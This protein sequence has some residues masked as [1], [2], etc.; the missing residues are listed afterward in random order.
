MTTQQPEALRLADM[1]KMGHSYDVDLFACS[2]E[3]RRQHARIA[4]LEAQL[5]APQSPEAA[6]VQLPE[7]AAWMDNGEIRSGSTATAHRVVTSDTKNSMPNASKVSFVNPLY[8]EQQVRQ[9]L[10]AHGIN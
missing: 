9:L 5:A 4:E 1:C 3:L 7:P 8:T 10:G 2:A 6:P